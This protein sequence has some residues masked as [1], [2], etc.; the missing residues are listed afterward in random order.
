MDGQRGKQQP[1]ET[2]TM[3][4]PA[5]WEEENESRSGSVGLG[6]ESQLVDGMNS[7]Q[8]AAV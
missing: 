5:C 1:N 7:R 4:L 8:I 3:R 6:H 2:S